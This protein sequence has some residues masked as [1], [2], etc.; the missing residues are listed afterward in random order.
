M[1]ATLAEDCA[2]D[3]ETA[4]AVVMSAV[5]HPGTIGAAIAARDAWAAAARAATT[6]MDAWFDSQS[7]I[8]DR[9]RWARDRASG[10]MGMESPRDPPPPPSQFVDRDFVDVD[11]VPGTTHTE[12]A[13][14]IFTKAQTSGMAA[15]GYTAH[16]SQAYR[17]FTPAEKT[18]ARIA[19]V[20]S[21]IHWRAVVE[22]LPRV[23]GSYHHADDCL[24]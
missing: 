2:N 8:T 5:D 4:L 10:L 16:S 19:P 6:A 15:G 20:V 14:R 9:L 11:S 3:A 12:I 7:R 24:L 23:L 1:E 21:V 13:R 17:L 22:R 18:R